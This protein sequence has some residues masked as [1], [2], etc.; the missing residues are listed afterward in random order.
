MP[1][2]GWRGFLR[3]G[4]TT[5]LLLL[6]GV[7]IIVALAMLP[8]PPGEIPRRLGEAV[9]SGP[10]AALRADDPDPSETAAELVSPPTTHAPNEV[11][12]VLDGEE[13]TVREVREIVREDPEKAEELVFTDEVTT[14]E[15]TSLLGGERPTEEQLPDPAPDLRVTV[16]PGRETDERAGEG[17]TSTTPSRGGTTE[18]RPGTTT[19]GTTTDPPTTTAP[20]PSVT[21]PPPPTVTEP[22]PPTVT[23]PPPPPVTEPPPPPVTEPPPPPV[24]E[25]PPPPVTEP[26][27]PPTTEPP[28]PPA[29]E[30]PSVTEPII[31]PIDEVIDDIVDKLPKPGKGIGRK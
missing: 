3:P 4:P 26:P 16:G 28:P 2:E 25:P 1:D 5:G 8:G 21:E 11:V 18:P 19:P 29:T 9:T 10:R 20:P 14:R 24:T 23:E 12:A 27:P 17:P 31:D 22:P 30:P 13:L 7:P 15:A 6:I